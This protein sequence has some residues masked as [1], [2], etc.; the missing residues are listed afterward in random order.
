MHCQICGKKFNSSSKVA[1]HK[2]TH[3]TSNIFTCEF[4]G[5]EKTFK[6]KRYLLAHSKLHQE[7][8]SHECEICRKILAG[9]R[10]MRA[11]LR[12]HTGEKPFTCQE[13]NQSFRNRSTYNTH[14]K[15]HMNKRNHVCPECNHSFIQLGDLRKHIRSKHTLEKPFSCDECGKTFARSDYLLKHTRAHKKQ[16]QQN[17]ND[18]DIEEETKVNTLLSEAMLEDDDDE[19]AL[20]PLEATEPLELVLQ[21]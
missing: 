13:C 2:H 7:R 15:R 5:C 12:V 10:E 17:S 3:Q 14:K 20:E 11:H 16:S 18:P 8:S 4:K 1:Q 9:P 19:V 21:Q 6:A